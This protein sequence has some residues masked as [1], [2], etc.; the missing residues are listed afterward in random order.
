MGHDLAALRDEKR[1]RHPAGT[2]LLGG[3]RALLLHRRIGHVILGPEAAGAAGV[4]FAP[5]VGGG[6]VWA[7]SVVTEGFRPESPPPSTD[8]STIVSTSTGTRI[9][10]DSAATL[11]LL[12]PLSS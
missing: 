8:A 1:L 2:E 11:R 4:R 9:R 10:A 7:C 5:P 6:E 3:V 12:I